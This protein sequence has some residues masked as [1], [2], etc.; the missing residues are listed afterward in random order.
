FA[1]I[2][3]VMSLEPHWF[4]TIYGIIYLVGEA[5][6]SLA[7]VIAVVML[8]RHHRALS[9]LVAPERLRDLGNLMLTFVMLWA[10]VQFSQFLIIWA[11]NLPDEIPWYLPRTRGGWGAIASL[12]ILFHF[13]APFFLLLSR[14]IKDRIDRLA[15]LAGLMLVVRLIDHFWL[16]APALHRGA[17]HIDWM[18]LAA[19]VGIGGLWIA[20]FLRR[21]RSAPLVPLHD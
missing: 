11:G 8:L 5:L 6:S 21:L 14:D 1:S 10:Y 7:L 3:W 16:I 17:L 4:S 2:D 15:R 18:D 12:L 20:V 19:P 9:G 13:F